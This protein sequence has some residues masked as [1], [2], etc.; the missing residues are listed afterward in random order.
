MT[1]SYGM[2]VGMCINMNEQDRSRRFWR[3]MCRRCSN[4]GTGTRRTRSMRGRGRIGKADAASAGHAP[5]P[6]ALLGDDAAKTVLR[7]VNTSRQSRFDLPQGCGNGRSPRGEG[8]SRA[9]LAVAGRTARPIGEESPSSSERGSANGWTRG[10][11]EPHADERP[12]HE[13]PHTD[14]CGQVPW[15]PDGRTAGL[16]G[17]TSV[18]PPRNQ[19]NRGLLGQHSA[20]LF[21]N[22]P[23]FARDHYRRRRQSY[24]AFGHP[25]VRQVCRS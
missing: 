11:R 7:A 22:L 1:A 18:Q 6:R 23:Q 14:L 2:N 8:G 19:F 3:S 10:R 15:Q 16:T 17:E 24:G 21:C 9:C 12:G 20:I 13:R 4:S 5:Q 25:Q